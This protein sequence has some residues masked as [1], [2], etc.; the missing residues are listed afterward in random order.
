M[1]W[2]ALAPKVSTE[3][4]TSTKEH[5]VRPDH[6]D[7]SSARLSRPD[8]TLESCAVRLQLSR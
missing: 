2:A 8:F 5:D 4:R 1:N 7:V 6:A 3:F